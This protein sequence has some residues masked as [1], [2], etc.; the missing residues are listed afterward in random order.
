MPEQ[1]EFVG[2]EA[3]LNAF[4][5]D[6]RAAEAGLP[7]VV[8]VG[9]EAG[10]GKTTLV[11]EAARRAGAPLISARATHVAHEPVALAPIADMVRQLRRLGHE[12]LIDQELGASLTDGARSG[13]PPVAEAV[14]HL[15]ERLGH[16]QTP[17][18]VFEDLH[19]ADAL[20]WDVF[21]F[22]ARNL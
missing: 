21:A 22:L 6:L 16:E 15:I 2:R 14:L 9:G 4:E 5:A 20:T 7:A 12:D 8:L 1:R 11:A 17:L 10:I 18:V 19:W 13:A 3:D